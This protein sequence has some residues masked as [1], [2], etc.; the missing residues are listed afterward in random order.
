MNVMAGANDLIV[1]AIA[2]EFLS[3]S[4]YLLT[5]FLRGDR[6]SI[7]GGLKYFLYGSITGAVMLFGLSYLYG[8]TG[9]TS[10]P[11][12]AAVA[13]SPELV[14]V[15]HLSAII[16][17]A[18]VM[19]LAGVSFKIAL[20]PFHQWSPDAYQAAPTPVTAFLS[21]GPKLAG[22][23][24]LARL[25]LANFPEPILSA[26]WLGLLGVISLL[27][28]ILGNFAALSQRNVKRMMAYSSIAQAGYM[29]VGL[30]TFG[31]ASFAGMDGVAAMIFM[32][33][34]YVFTNL[35]VFAV[36]IAV[37]DATGSAEI[38][39]FGGLMR[40]S[41]LLAVAMVVF[42][43]SLVGIP[44]LSGFV[45]KFAVFG[46]AVTGGHGVLALVG[47]LTGVVSVAY[48]FA[49]VKQMFFVD[50]AAGPIRPGLGSTFVILAA[51]LMTL[52]LGVWPEAFLPLASSVADVVRPAVEA[53]VAGP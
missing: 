8:V 16:L 42:F 37:E 4:S 53:V 32:L 14:Q 23:A 36:I 10:I 38:E 24:V 13:R 15:Q 29:L 40:R 7:E 52:L 9:T 30:V 31:A 33:L 12:L 22:F 6:L 51:L 48:Y 47:V 34:T 1:V 26:T 35:G 27:T 50:A 46:S 17:P 2:I 49:V 18:L 3:I 5:A 19:V 28:M 44:P 39:A 11:A 21:V 45:A 43:L 25:L 20:V 41:P